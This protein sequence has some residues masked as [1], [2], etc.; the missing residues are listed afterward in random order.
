MSQDLDDE[1]DWELEDDDDEDQ[2][3][4]EDPTRQLD[5]DI[6]PPNLDQKIYDDIVALREK[7]LDLDEA[8]TDE[9]TVLQSLQQTLGQTQV[10]SNKVDAELKSKH[11]DLI[12]FQVR[13]NHSS[14]FSYHFIFP[15]YRKRNNEK[16]MILMSLSVFVLIKFVMIV[17]LIYL[18]IYQ[19]H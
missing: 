1:E 14:D 8:I 16:L 6:C 5:V 9:K 15:I 13:E 12:D 17:H 7:R 2:I 18:T 19:M 10:Y 3:A 4:N 11:A